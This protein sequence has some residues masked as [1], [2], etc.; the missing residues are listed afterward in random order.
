LT[1]F[2][3]QQTA[4][5]TMTSDLLRPRRFRL[6][7]INCA[8]CSTVMICSLLLLSIG[9]AIATLAVDA[10][11]VDQVRQA[12]TTDD[13]NEA[14]AAF[15]N[16]W[17]KVHSNGSSSRESRLK[18]LVSSSSIQSDFT[19]SPSSSSSPTSESPGSPSI[20]RTRKSR[21]IDKQSTSGSFGNCSRCVEHKHARLRRL[22][23]IKNEILSK[24]SMSEPPMIETNQTL[25]QLSIIQDIFSRSLSSN[26]HA[27]GDFEKL[28]AKDEEYNRQSLGV[29]DEQF[30]VNPK[31]TVSFAMPRKCR[32]T[33][34]W[35]HLTKTNLFTPFDS[36]LH[37]PNLT[38]TSSRKVGQTIVAFEHSIFRIQFESDRRSRTVGATV[39][40]RCS[41]QRSANRQRRFDSTVGVQSSASLA[42]RIANVDEGQSAVMVVCACALCSSL[43][44][45]HLKCLSLDFVKGARKERPNRRSTGKLDQCGHAQT[46]D[47][48]VPASGRK[49]WSGRG[50]VRRSRQRLEHQSTGR[51]GFVCRN[52]CFTFQSLISASQSN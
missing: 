13:W 51:V 16:Q 38:L 47:H 19:L 46:V 34:V 33:K 26:V 37:F 22:H 14:V 12:L 6:A 45:I 43:L 11:T 39:R 52:P 5:I 30:Y 20:D 42:R 40:L 23:E 35:L 21:S 36:F 8:T 2:S 18:Y 32:T 4:S 7:P 31:R 27:N 9:R 15:Q 24:L 17:R 3:F 1:C 49:S 25:P 50:S 28:M 41:K 10:D 48:L 29:D 44:M